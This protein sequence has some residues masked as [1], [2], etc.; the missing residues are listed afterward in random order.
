M[1]DAKKG[2]T[3]AVQLTLSDY[4]NFEDGFYVADDSDEWFPANVRAAFDP[5]SET[6]RVV[7]SPGVIVG[8]RLV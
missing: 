6:W 4:D 1:I 2:D 8:K 7:V 3:V 5:V